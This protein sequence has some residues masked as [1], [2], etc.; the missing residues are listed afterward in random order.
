MKDIY[1]IEK[2][3]GFT[4]VELLAVIVVI[5]LLITLGAPITSNIINDAKMNTF[6]AYVDKIYEDVVAR[7]ESDA[8]VNLD[9]SNTCVVYDIE[10]SLGLADTGEN[11]GYVVVYPSVNGNKYYMNIHNS[12]FMVSNYEYNNK[13]NSKVTRYLK[14]G[15]NGFKTNIDEYAISDLG[16]FSYKCVDCDSEKTEPSGSGSGASATHTQNGET[17][18]LSGTIFN[19]TIKRLVSGK[20]DADYNTVDTNLKV[21]RRTNAPISNGTVL[22]D[23][24]ATTKIFAQYDSSNGVLSWYSSSNKVY[25]P[26]NASYMFYNFQ[27]LEAIDNQGDI[28]SPKFSNISLMFCY[29]YKLGVIG[30]SKWDVSNVSNFNYAFRGCSS[31]DYLDV[32]NWNTSNAST[33]QGIFMACSNLKTIDV[34]NWN[35][36][37]ATNLSQVFY[38]CTNLTGTMDLSHTS[39]DNATDMSQMFGCADSVTG[40]SLEYVYLPETIS[41]VKN[42]NGVFVNC[43]KLKKIYNIEKI[44]VSNLTNLTGTFKNCNK[45]EELDLSSW[46][47]TNVTDMGWVFQNCTS[48]KELDLSNFNFSRVKSLNGVFYN[49][50]ALEKIVLKNKNFANVTTAELTFQNCLKLKEIDLSNANMPLVTSAK[51]MFGNCQTLEKLDLSNIKLNSNKSL[52]GTF[53]NLYE[54]TSINLSGFEDTALEDFATA[55][56]YCYKLKNI[57]LSS[58]NATKVNNMSMT[59]FADKE[60]ETL[61]LSGVK[62]NKVTNMINT[63][64]TCRKLRIIYISNDWSNA[65]L[66]SDKKTSTFFNCDSLEGYTSS[67]AS[68]DYAKS[69]DKGGYFTIKA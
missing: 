32:S 61:D 25:W 7:Y 57:D 68:G 9:Y 43:L 62:S 27:G 20:V 66:A 37:K 63:F 49:C 4:L 24:S 16:C 60:L 35:L 44:N 34:T 69:K 45:L 48:L 23:S 52:N 14:V 33:L 13:T 41:K 54:L 18:F 38:N 58:L 65:S 39:F 51:G 2:K 55:F 19:K 22:S 42:L 1:T 53:A 28:L 15:D 12:Q 29:C 50:Q 59:F 5:A 46:K 3:K 31:L 40:N 56:G 64:N 47:C 67:K 17:Q 21:I 6:A 30:V 36:K 10:D 11:K 26:A 8:A